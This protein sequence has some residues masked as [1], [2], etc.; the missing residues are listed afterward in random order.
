MAFQQIKGW[1]LDYI[2]IYKKSQDFFILFYFY[3]IIYSII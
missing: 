3:F 1:Y 2:G